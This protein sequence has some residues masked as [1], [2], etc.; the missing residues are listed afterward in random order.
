MRSFGTLKNSGGWLCRLTGKVTFEEGLGGSSC[1]RVCELRCS[2]CRDV[3]E[4]KAEF[5]EM[6]TL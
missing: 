5:L 3:E 6:N 4:A 2:R 1:V